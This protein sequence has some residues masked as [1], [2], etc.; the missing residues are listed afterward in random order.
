MSVHDFDVRFVITLRGPY[1]NRVRFWDVGND[2]V[3]IGALRR[4]SV[5]QGLSWTG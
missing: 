5:N 3:R 4:L 1:S 2:T